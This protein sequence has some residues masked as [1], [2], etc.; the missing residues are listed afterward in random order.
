M[1]E[2]ATL[3]LAGEVPLG[4]TGLQPA[5]QG[6]MVTQGAMDGKVLRLAGNFLIT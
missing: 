2:E 6:D 5:A 1:H 4:G 3:T